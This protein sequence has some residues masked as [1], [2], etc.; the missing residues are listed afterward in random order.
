MVIS[1]LDHQPTLSR[2]TPFHITDS[3]RQNDKQWR[4]PAKEAAMSNAAVPPIMPAGA[5]PPRSRL[6]KWIAPIAVG[7]ILFLIPAPAGLEPAAWHY[8]ALFA[9]VIAGLITEP[10]P[11]AAVG[12]I[13]VTIAAA[14]KMVGKTPA[15]ATSWALSGFSND[16]VWLIF[17]ANMFALGYDLTG[18]G[19]RMALMLVKALGRHTLGLGYAVAFSDLCLSPVMPSNTARSGGTVYP[20]VKNIPPLYGSLPNDHPR[21]MGGY[22][23]WT[24]FAATC[25]TSS[26]FLTALAPNLLAVEIARKVAHVEC[27]WGQWA[28]GFLPVGLLLFFAVPAL[29]Y[30][31]YPPEVKRGD[32]VAEWAGKELAAMGRASRSELTM[33]ALALAAL[34]GWIFGT[35]WITPVTVALAAIALM[36]LAKVV[37]WADIV[38]NKQSWTVLVWFA[39]LVALAEGLGKVGFLDWFGARAAGAMTRIPMTAMLVAT[40][41]L[42]FLIHYLFASITAQATA[43]LPVFLLAVLSVPGVPAKAITLV[44]AYSL[45]L[46]GVLTPYA[47]GPAPIWYSSGY[48]PAKDFWRL[49]GIFGAFFLAVLLLVGLPWAIAVLH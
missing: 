17:A 18:L 43:L 3:P 39:T 32:E 35:R 29:A 26:M 10:L 36:L 31:L 1:D 45:G 28:L 9:A 13:G 30:V 2:D 4:L 25:V 47:S 38:A 24:G 41:A 48:I 27:S 6:G 49:G 16:A 37:T 11:G 12:F 33:L 46:M 20:I 22:L 42:F 23:I 21:R 34:A 15:A 19:R 5:A 14:L 44:L 8:F 7:A 40:V